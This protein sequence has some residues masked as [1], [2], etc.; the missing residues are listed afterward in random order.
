[1]WHGW[2]VVCIIRYKK[3]QPMNVF[4]ADEKVFKGVEIVLLVDTRRD[5]A[6]ESAHADRS[7]SDNVHRRHRLFHD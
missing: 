7:L 5:L 2:D 1:M 3:Q 4:C 6:L